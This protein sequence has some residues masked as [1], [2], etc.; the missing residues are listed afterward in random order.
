VVKQL[1][2]KLVNIG[3]T[4]C[5]ILRLRC[6][7]FDSGGAYHAPKTLKGP[8]FK[9]RAGKGR[10]KAWERGGEGRLKGKGSS[11]PLVEMRFAIMKLLQR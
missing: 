3:A 2:G 9:G 6:S 5:Q 1:S 11:V 10:R 7:K 8:T 4:R